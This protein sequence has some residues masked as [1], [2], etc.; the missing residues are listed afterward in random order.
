MKT[1][2]WH[3]WLK[4]I[5]SIATVSAVA[6][7]VAVSLTSTPTASADPRCLNNDPW[8]TYCVGGEILREFNAV[9]GLPF[10]GNATRGESDARNGGKWQSFQRSSIYWHPGVPGGNNGTVGHANQIGGAILTKWGRYPNI[11]AGQAFEYGPLGYPTTRERGTRQSPYGGVTG[12][13]NHFQG[14]SI[15]HSRI[16]NI[17]QTHVV[18]GDIRQQWEGR[19]WEAGNMGFPTSDEVRCVDGDTNTPESSYGGHG[20][21]FQGG[22]L[23]SNTGSFELDRTNVRQTASGPVMTYE[24]VATRYSSQFNSAAASWNQVGAKVRVTAGTPGESDLVVYDT[25]R[26][27]LPSNVLGF[28]TYGNPVGFIG[29]FP[30]RIERTSYSNQPGNTIAHELGHALKLRHSCETQLMDPVFDP[31]TAPVPQWVDSYELKR[32]WGTR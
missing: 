29:L 11:T 13:F 5:G 9:G 25:D 28:Y 6:V 20:Q 3:R 23:L 19:N 31:N 1:H 15:Y 12:R 26:T 30:D 18:W 2:K 7:A 16:N 24:T 14:G 32:I 10:F 8:Y 17:D 22:W 21:F 27:D 4:S